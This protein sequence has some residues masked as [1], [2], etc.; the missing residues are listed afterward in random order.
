M[1]IIYGIPIPL[2]YL[3][4]NLLFYPLKL[5][6]NVVLASLNREIIINSVNE[7]NI[8]LNEKKD[9]LL[10]V[11]TLMKF[12]NIPYIIVNDMLIDLNRKD[13]EITIDDN[14][15]FVC[16]SNYKSVNN[17][18]YI[19]EKFL[20]NKIKHLKLEC[21]INNNNNNNFIYFH[22][23]RISQNTNKIE[24]SITD[25]LKYKQNKKYYYYY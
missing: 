8:K 25:T 23:N 2:S 4:P 5:P 17:V 1:K 7:K 20:K 9:H 10:F 15:D 16:I 22:C 18:I 11:K 19:S 13:F 3:T 24:Q 14:D 21:E 6:E 12:L